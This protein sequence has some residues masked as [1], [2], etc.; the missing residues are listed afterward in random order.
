VS[1]IT[2]KQTLDDLNIFG[3]RGQDSLFTLFNRT[4]TPG[5]AEQLE[6]MF[7][8]PF[9]DPAQIR[10]RAGTIQFFQQQKIRF[11]IDHDLFEAAVHYLE[12][13]DGRSRLTGEQP[14]AGRFMKTIL[15]TDATF[16]TI[17]KGIL[18]LIKILNHL[19]DHVQQLKPIVAAGHPY[20]EELSKMESL[21]RIPEWSLFFER[22]PARPGFEKLAAYDQLLRFRFHEEVQQLL[23]LVANIDVYMAV[24]AVAD[25]KGFV[26]PVLVEDRP[27]LLLEEVYHPHLQKP[28]GNNLVLSTDMNLVFLTG[29]NMAGKST[30]MKSVAI[31]VYLAH[32]GFPVPAA[33]MT[34]S[35]RDGML[36]TINLPDNLS[37]G[38]SH[39]YTE[40]LRAKKIAGLLQ[41][42][43]K[44]MVL[45]D[46]LFRGTNVKDAY[47]ATVAITGKFAMQR[48]SFF[49]ISS[50]IMEAGEKLQE[51]YRNISF[52]FLPTKMEGHQPVY[53]RKLEAGISADRHGMIIIQNEGI[54]DMLKRSA[55]KKM[56]TAKP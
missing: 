1:F 24:A 35:A 12:M 5:G 43:K 25:A 6:M 44:M 29:A 7:R 26:F 36:T 49:I 32:M 3:K 52:Q 41:Q 45:I 10:K 8:Y 28:V 16:C 19:H 34:F 17:K 50:H 9:S 14:P 27:L 48:Q 20:E 40:V 38:Y 54:L 4:A 56:L 31:A 55:S 30:F 11:T 2:D 13:R 47:E 18:S 51:H 15:R 42:G 23:S 33:A 21:L 22:I 37:M 39:F 53:P 46:E